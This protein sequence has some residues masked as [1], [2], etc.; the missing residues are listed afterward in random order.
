[1]IGQLK[2]GETVTLPDGRVI[3]PED[4]YTGNDKADEKSKLLIVDIENEEKLNSIVNNSNMM[5]F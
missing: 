3:H 2:A 4:V 1:M 5:V